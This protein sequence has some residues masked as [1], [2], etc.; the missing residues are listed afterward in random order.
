[1]RTTP[2]TFEDKTTVDKHVMSRDG[3]SV[4]A[5]MRDGAFRRVRPVPEWRGKAQRRQV[6]KARRA[7]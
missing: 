2:Y 5:V 3:V 1:M 6:L 4:Y 7:A